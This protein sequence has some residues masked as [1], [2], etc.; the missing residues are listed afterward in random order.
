MDLASKLSRLSIDARGGPRLM[1]RSVPNGVVM[2]D[3][4]LPAAGGKRELAR[5]CLYN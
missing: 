3:A 2:M 4:E 5:A 1:S